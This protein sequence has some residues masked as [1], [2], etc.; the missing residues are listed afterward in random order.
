[1]AHF[2]TTKIYKLTSPQT[3]KIY[4]GYTIANLPKKLRFHQNK[5]RRYLNGTIGYDKS[6]EI[7][8]YADH[9]I[10]WL[11]DFPCEYKFRIDHRLYWWIRVSDTVNVITEPQEEYHQA[12]KKQILLWLNRRMGIPC[13]EESRSNDP[14]P[15]VV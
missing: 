2:L 13:K 14:S 5:Y 8:R 4:I 3:E 1:M 7:L 6:F 12:N 10:E 9:M 15:D 11:E